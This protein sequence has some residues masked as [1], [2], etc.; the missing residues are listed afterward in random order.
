[1][2]GVMYSQSAS[3]AQSLPPSKLAQARSFLFVP[4]NR[5]ERFAK[6]LAS[7][8]PAEANG[9]YRVNENGPELLDISGRQYLMMGSQGGNVVPNDKLGGRT[10]NVVI[11]PPAGMSRRSSN[12]F[13]ADVA[14]ELRVA[15]LRN[16]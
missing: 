13:A 3:P 8:G 12:Q 15:D 14:R 1:M 2:S 9:F 11:N 7:G 16:N 5:P 4:G 6:A 10:M